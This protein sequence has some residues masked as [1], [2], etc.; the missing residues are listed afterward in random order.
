MSRLYLYSS[1]DVQGRWWD[2]S[3]KCSLKCGV[4]Y[5]HLPVKMSWL[6]TCETGILTR[7]FPIGQKTDSASVVFGA[8][9]PILY[10]LRYSFDSD[11]AN[12]HY[13]VGLWVERNVTGYFEEW[14]LLLISHGI[15][16]KVQSR[17]DSA[18]NV[19]SCIYSFRW[20]RF[21]AET[22]FKAFKIMSFEGSSSHKGYTWQTIFYSNKIP[23]TTLR[24]VECSLVLWPGFISFIRRSR[25]R[26]IAS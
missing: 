13:T 15:T 6:Q 1:D 22:I 7:N 20:R 12:P 19:I 14:G 21:A 11:R 4:N 26:N 9:D 3:L 25:R 17:F 24:V 16:H 23:Y 8:S 18:R 5:L 2:A 10:N